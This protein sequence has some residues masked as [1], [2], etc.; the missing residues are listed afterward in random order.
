MSFQRAEQNIVALG[1][2]PRTTD[3]HNVKRREL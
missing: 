3:D 1:V 2:D